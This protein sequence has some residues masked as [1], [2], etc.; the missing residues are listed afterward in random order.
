[1]KVSVVVPTYE[2]E[3][4]I[5]AFL[6]QFA[7]QTLP[8]DAFEIV[9]VDGGSRDRTREI[10]ERMADRVVL[11]AGQGIG[12]ARNDGVAVARAPLIATT[13]ADC[14]VPEDWLERI[15]RHFEDPE[16]V[17]VC[18]PDGP[19]ERSWKARGTFFVVR[20][21]IRLAALAGVYGTGGTNSA[22]RKDAFRSVGG[23]RALPHSDDI[24]LGVRIRAR[25]RVVYDPRL[26]VRL[27]VRRLER[28]GYMRT[29]LLWLRGD[30]KVLA[31]KPI[32]AA[33]Y[34]RQK[35]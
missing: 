5:E 17:A 7:R 32:D 21:L 14:I 18:G 1:V 19:I 33:E 3:G 16:V 23:Y 15:V 35:Y 26:Y 20:S 2:E 6:G 11:Q 27:S 28:D 29:L 8:R 30:L 34:A 25:G 22:F 9:L 12:G 4:R 10:G 24:D 31:G 13:D